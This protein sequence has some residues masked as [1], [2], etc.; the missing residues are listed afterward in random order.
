L[1]IDSE[2]IDLFTGK[3]REILD[4]E[5]SINNKI[6]ETYKENWP[7]KGSIVIILEK[8]FSPPIFKNI[9]GVEFKNINDPHYW[10][11]EYYDKK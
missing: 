7:Y 10:K 3:L 1:N 5:L 8:P 4:F 2:I 11:A 6:C 9:S